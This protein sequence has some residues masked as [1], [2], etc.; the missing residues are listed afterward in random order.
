MPHQHF[1]HIFLF[2]HCHESRYWLFWGHYNAL[3]FPLE[4][5]LQLFPGLE[6]VYLLGRLKLGPNTPKIFIKNTNLMKNKEKMAAQLTSNPLRGITSFTQDRSGNGVKD[7][8][9]KISYACCLAH[10]KTKYSKFQLMSAYFMACRWFNWRLATNKKVI[11]AP[12]ATWLQFIL[13][14]CGFCLHTP[15]PECLVIYL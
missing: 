15:Y 6:L 2:I 14:C 12:L 11:S 4:D 5:N 10:C 9:Q 1:I 13:F 7:N 3:N 8:I